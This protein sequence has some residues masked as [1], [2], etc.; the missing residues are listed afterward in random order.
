MEWTEY[1]VT[2]LIIVLT[3]LISLRTFNDADLK[4]KLIFYPYKVKREKEYYRFFSH[5]LIHGDYLHLFFNMFVLFSF[6]RTIEYIFVHEFGLIAGRL[7]FLLLY[8]VGGL[9]AGL[10]PYYRNSDNPNY[11]SLGASGAVSA[12]L[13]ASII[14]LPY[15]GIYIMFIPFEIKAWLFG[16]IYLGF[17][18]YMSKRNNNSGIAH[19]AHFGGAVFGILFILIVQPQKGIEFIHY[20]LN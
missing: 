16:I 18:Y 3:V 8:V 10:W 15:G 5:Q 9:V 4:Y 14:W 7:Y 17:E 13:F 6:G 12:V 1:P 2:L 11:M 20:I 19:D